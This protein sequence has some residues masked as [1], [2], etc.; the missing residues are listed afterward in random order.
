[1]SDYKNFVYGLPIT[2]GI[3]GHRDIRDTDKVREILREQLQAIRPR[4][5]NTPLYALSALAEGADRLF[6]QLALDCG[7]QLH[8]ILP[9]APEVYRVDFISEESKS[10][11]DI[12][13]KQAETCTTVRVVVPGSEQDVTQKGLHRD[14]QYAEAGIQMAQCSH[15]LIALWDGKPAVGLGGTAQIVNFRETGYLDLEGTSQ[16]GHVT[17][18]IRD[19]LLPTNPLYPPETGLVCKIFCDRQ[20]AAGSVADGC[21]LHDV[22]WTAGSSREE[23]DIRKE[24]SLA[25]LFSKSS[26]FG[27]HET[28]Q[29]LDSLN[30]IV[31]WNSNVQKALQ[32]EPGWPA[33]LS[34]Y[35]T[36][37]DPLRTPLL[38]TRCIVDK[39]VTKK[40][41]ERRGR[42]KLVFVVM[43]VALLIGSRAPGD[44][45]W[46]VTL[47]LWGQLLALLGLAYLLYRRGWKGVPEDYIEQRALTEGLRIQDHW[48]TIGVRDGVSLHYM[49]HEEDLL[50]RVSYALKGTRFGKVS[51]DRTVDAFRDLKTRWID[52]QFMYYSGKTKPEEGAVR[53][54]KRISKLLFCF[55]V[56]FL[57]SVTIN[58]SIGFFHGEGESSF[59]LLFHIL[60][61]LAEL[62][63]ELCALLLAY[64]EFSGDTDNVEDYT[65]AKYLFARAQKQFD[66][67]LKYLPDVSASVGKETSLGVEDESQ[68]EHNLRHVARSLG[69]EIL[70]GDTARWVERSLKQKI[71]LLK[72]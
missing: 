45:E 69:I 34:E 53:Y 47:S 50:Q 40:I 14:L 32:H 12:L 56:L 23:K 39:I 10:E 72:R 64:L 25:V 24:E 37:P 3:T 66:D 41:S 58:G 4:F 55:G 19:M 18:R 5:P 22:E 20:S 16:S 71:D 44:P 59:E 17:P 29:I 21:K 46:W 27:E 48:N 61:H 38:G 2:V 30:K 62:L 31:S 15:I 26:T 7:W 57:V 1:M 63:I 43:A 33:S 70:T 28:P 54:L 9:L 42:L 11:F 8:V 49:H 35:S 36:A 6:A 65:R 52:D 51:T 67:N 68:P 60:E 13:C